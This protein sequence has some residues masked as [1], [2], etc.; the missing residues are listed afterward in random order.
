MKKTFNIAVLP[1][2][3]IGPEVTDAAVAVLKKIAGKFSHKF[4]F[5]YGDFGAVAIEKTGNP[6]PEPTLNICLKSDA[7]LLGAIGDPKFD[8]DPN[9]PVR[10]EQGLL[11]LR[12][13]LNLFVNLRPVKAYKDL[14]DS[15]PLKK[16]RIEGVDL[17]IVRELTGGI[18]F[19]EPRMRTGNGE[20]AIDTSI[21]TKEEIMRVAKLAF[22]IAEKRNKKVISVDKANVLETSRLWRETVNEIAKFYPDIEI[23][24]M[25]VDNAAMQLIKNPEQFDVIL[26]ENMMGDIL[27][28]EASVIAGS[29]GLLPSASI[30]EKYA[31]Y[32]PIHGA[33]NKAAGKNIANPIGTILSAAMMLRMSFGLGKE[34]EAIEKA[35]ERTIQKGYRTKDILSEKTDPKKILGTHEMGEKIRVFLEKN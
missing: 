23:T 30:G 20:K 21:Y 35:V 34:S 31:L 24:H 9:A 4:N 7:I 3:G 2:D 6:L 29:I 25:Y 1:G 17:M 26:T 18:Y 19:G 22:K 28:D 15:S 33:F 5:L 16:E 8:S 13:T 32:E 12:K 27:T 10:P 11:K 14:I